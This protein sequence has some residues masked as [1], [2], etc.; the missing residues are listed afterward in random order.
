MCLLKKKNTNQNVILSKTFEIKEK[1][2]LYTEKN[3]R[4]NWNA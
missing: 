3:L 4:V 2:F 1:T